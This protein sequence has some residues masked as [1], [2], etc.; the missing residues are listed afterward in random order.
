MV[1]SLITPQGSNFIK[2]FPGQNTV[3]LDRIDNY[4]GPCLRTQPVQSFTPSLTA[5]T[6]AP[7]LGVGG[8]N[9]G[10]FYEIFDQIYMWGEF[11]FGTSGFSAG[12]GIYT[13]Q[14]PFDVQTTLGTSITP[15]NTPNVGNASLFDSSSNA[16]RLP[17]T[18]HLNTTNTLFFATKMNNGIGT[19]LLIDSGYITW[20]AN[21]GV[22]WQARFQRIP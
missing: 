1:L 16:G 2:D 21:D 14:I 4:A 18:V 17:M 22:S 19:R 13:V 7:N 5:S 15:G 11:R 3:N 8:F 6:T 10:F 12:S 20:A 9:K